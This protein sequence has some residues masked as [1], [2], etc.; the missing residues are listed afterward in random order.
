MQSQ[1][2]C[3]ILG[4]MLAAMNSSGSDRN[5]FFVQDLGLAVAPKMCPD[6]SQAF[7]EVKNG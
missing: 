7:K 1:L 3:H 2:E 4:I 6:Q 5:V